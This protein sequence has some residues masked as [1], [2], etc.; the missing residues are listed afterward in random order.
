MADALLTAPTSVSVPEPDGLAVPR[1]FGA[2]H[3]EGLGSGVSLGGGGVFFVAWQV[4]YLAALAERGVDV[5]GASRVVGTSAGSLVAAVL[6]AGNIGRFRKEI[7]FLSKV[8]KLVGMLAPAA[9]LK[10]SQ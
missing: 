5:A 2:G 4:A 9:R 3:G 7:G 1:D 8:P 10:P 6:E